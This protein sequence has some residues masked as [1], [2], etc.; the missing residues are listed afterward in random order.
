[1]LNFQLGFLKEQFYILLQ[2]N[3]K[4]LDLFG[5]LKNLLL[6]FRA[7]YILHN[8]YAEEYP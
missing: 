7:G 3:Y 4:I 2:E 8:I 6:L 1:M 5:F